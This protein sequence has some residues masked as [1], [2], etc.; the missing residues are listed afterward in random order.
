MAERVMIALSKK[1]MSRQKAHE[2]VRELAQ[3]VFK[4]GG[5]LKEEIKKLE[6]FSGKE[7]EELFDY[8]TYVGEAEK[9]VENAVK[10]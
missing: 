2:L 7:L 8:S 10:E 5:H 3:K 4:K 9:I 6:K 1:G